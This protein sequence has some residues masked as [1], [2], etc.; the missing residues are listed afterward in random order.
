MAP[1]LFGR[2]R[3]TCTESKREN[4]SRGLAHVF[5]RRAYI[6]R[7]KRAQFDDFVRQITVV[8]SRIRFLSKLKLT[9]F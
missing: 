1:F 6:V 7:V 8:K 2:R 4:I 9:F 5:S 3:I